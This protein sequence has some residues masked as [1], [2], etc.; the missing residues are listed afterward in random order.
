MEMA[1][2]SLVEIGG[3]RASL[4]RF[5]FLSLASLGGVDLHA[6]TMCI[7]AG[8]VVGLQSALATAAADGDDDIIK[9]Q[10]GQ[11]SMGLGFLLDYEAYTEHHD[12]TIEGGYGPN[13][14]DPCG[15]PPSSPDPRSTVL[16]GGSV[17]GMFRLKMNGGATGTFALKALT[18]ANANSVSDTEP[19]VEIF[20]GADANSSVTIDNVVFANN[21][22]GNNTAVYVFANQGA[23]LAHN[24]LFVSNKTWASVSPIRLGSLQVSG[25]FCGEVINSTFTDNVAILA[26]LPAVN[27]DAQCSTIVANDI[28]WGNP[29]GD[30]SFSNPQSSFLISDDFGD[31]SGTANTQATNILSVDP[32]FVAGY[33]IHDLSPLRNLGAPG[34]FVFTPGQYDVIGNP[35]VYG[36]YPDIGA[37]EIQDVIFAHGFDFQPPF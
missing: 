9:L 3:R 29:N 16:D 20:G 30:V 19:P 6:A 10:A 1:G 8:D 37:Y 33:A 13:F 14:G 25:S 23:L 32:F 2:L 31:L 4:V 5:A 34:G 35:R 36:A 17:G 22:S 21:F 26:S 7:Q 18:I 24:V 11:Y 27:I 12:L 15:L 28:F